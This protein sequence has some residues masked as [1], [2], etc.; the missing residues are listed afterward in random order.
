MYITKQLKT[1][2]Y[3]TSLCNLLLQ[4]SYDI[5]EC[6]QKLINRTCRKKTI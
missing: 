2:T 6:K 3:K 5:F 4:H 1:I